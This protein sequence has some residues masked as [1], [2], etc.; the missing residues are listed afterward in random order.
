M[1]WQSVLERHPKHVHA[2]GMIS[3]EQAN[4]DVMLSDLLAIILDVPRHLGQAVFLT[5]NSATARIQILKNVAKVAFPTYSLAGV[6]NDL[7]EVTKETNQSREHD[8]KRVEAI[9]R[10]AN[11]I[12]G[13]RNN[14]IHEVWGLN[15]D[16]LAVERRPL[17]M[18]PSTRKTLVPIQQLTDLIRDIRQLV[19]ETVALTHEF[20]FRRSQVHLAT[21]RS[22]SPDKTPSQNHQRPR[23]VKS[24][25][26]PHPPKRRRQRRSS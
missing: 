10:R 26:K 2:I 7:L 18:L 1:T 15:R 11:A 13:K 8:R 23:A 6:G 9:A 14:I 4:L 24:S 22:P 20:S 16:T 12:V 19:T 25:S 21:V 5:P 17:P 3:I